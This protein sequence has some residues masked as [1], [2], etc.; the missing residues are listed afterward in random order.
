MLSSGF[1]VITLLTLFFFYLA[2]GQN[3]LLLYTSILWLLFIGGLSLQDF[4]T[5][6][7][8]IPPR[9]LLVFIGAISLMVYFY[10]ILKNKNLYTNYLFLVHGVR[11]PVEITLYQLYLKGEVP[12]MMTFGGW[13]YDIFIGIS[14]L[15]LFVLAQINHKAVN[16]NFLFIWNVVGI[17]FLTIIVFTAILSA[18][19][20]IQQLAFDHPNV[21]IQKFPFIFLPAFIVPI[22]YLSH[23]LSLKKL[24]NEVII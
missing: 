1:I 15:I 18:P 14:A 12:I 13:N 17:L 2:S 16:K 24:K 4:F 7:T 5:N 8:S 9:F 21:A 22:V 20:P 23:F 3:R 10:R 11:L 6:T 19:L